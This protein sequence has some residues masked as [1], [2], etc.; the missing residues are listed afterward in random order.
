MCNDDVCPI[1]YSD[2]RNSEA[3]VTTCK[4]VFHSICLR[5][6]LYIQDTCPMCQNIVYGGKTKPQ[7][8]LEQDNFE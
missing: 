5:K 4:H 7:E 6:W 1:C 3:R 8:D 2:I